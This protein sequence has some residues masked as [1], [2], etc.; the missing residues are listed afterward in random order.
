MSDWIAPGFLGAREARCLADLPGFD[1]ER[2]P[3]IGD[4]VHEGEEIL[5]QVVKDP[6]RREGRAAFG[7]RHHSRPL[8]R[9]GAQSAGHRA[10]APHRGRRRTRAHARAWR[11][12]DRGGRRRSCPAPDTSCARA[13][14]DADT[15]RSEGR[16]RASRRSLA[17][18]A[19][20]APTG[21][22]A[23]DALSRSR[24]RRAHHA[25]QVRRR[26]QSRADRRCR[27]GRSRARLLPPRHAGSG[28]QDRV[29]HRPR[30]A[31]R[32][33]RSRGRDRPADRS[34]A[35]RCRPAAGSRSKA[36]RR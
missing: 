31:V 35:C 2:T 20:E 30:H 13:A 18:G 21:D 24:S 4:C 28:K 14:I 27:S 34:R 8:A 32:P 6:D 3:K 22:V 36:P 10:V 5:V 15:A 26:H 23:G 7:Q 11:S 16:C 1:E 19:G 25:R 29:V 17:A 9:A 12:D 33:L